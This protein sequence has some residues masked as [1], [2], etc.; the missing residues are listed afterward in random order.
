MWSSVSEQPWT[1][2]SFITI[3]TITIE[4]MVEGSNLIGVLFPLENKK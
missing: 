1:V 3:V 4:L 2:W